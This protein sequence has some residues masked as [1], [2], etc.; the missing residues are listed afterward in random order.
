L[1]YLR[2]VTGEGEESIELAPYITNNTLKVIP[3]EIH[4]PRDQLKDK[5]RVVVVYRRRWDESLE[6]N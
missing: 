5:K 2:Q 3:N 4:C 6:V 1:D